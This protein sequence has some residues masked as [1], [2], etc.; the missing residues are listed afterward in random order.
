M[1]CFWDLALEPQVGPATVEQRL[2]CACLCWERTGAVT[3]R[4]LPLTLVC[5]G[6]AEMPADSQ[7][8]PLPAL[9][10][11]PS[12]AWPGLLGE[13]VLCRSRAE[14]AWAGSQTVPC[15]GLYCAG[16][17]VL[18]CILGAAASSSWADP[19]EQPVPLHSVLAP[20]PLRFLAPFCPC[21]LPGASWSG[22]FAGC[23]QM[24]PDRSCH[25]PGKTSGPGDVASPG[26]SAGM[27][28]AKASEPSVGV[29]YCVGAAGWGVWRDLVLSALH[30]AL[31]LGEESGALQTGVRGGLPPQE[32][33]EV[34]AQGGE[35]QA[36]LLCIIQGTGRPSVSS[37]PA[38]GLSL[39]QGNVET[40]CPRVPNSLFSLAAPKQHWYL[41]QRLQV[42]L[43][44]WC[45]ALEVFPGPVMSLAAVSWREMLAQEPYSCLSI[46]QVL[47]SATCM[48]VTYRCLNWSQG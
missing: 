26:R 8:R 32:E 45:S 33:V 20:G 15:V 31:E 46:M 48:P 10:C 7:G 3:S 42:G 1:P 21:P 41:A 47:G 6:V 14:G 9:S 19:A 24:S 27:R 30:A 39:P 18:A 29:V 43:D 12:P 16:S 40:R 25:H 35:D 5:Q 28:E 17:G 22:R 13:M 44:T 38:R 4:M 23:L 11:P 37:S 36:M 2:V 34:A